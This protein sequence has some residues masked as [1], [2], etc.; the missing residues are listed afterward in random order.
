[1]YPKLVSLLLIQTHFSLHRLIVITSSKS[2]IVILCMHVRIWL[3]TNLNQ[4]TSIYPTRNIPNK[5]ALT[6]SPLKWKYTESWY[7]QFLRAICVKISPL[8]TL[9][10][11][12]KETIDKHDIVQLIHI[13]QS[14]VCM[15]V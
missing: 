6:F 3:K 15:P 11:R 13:L 12:F 7:I 4:S 5:N 10:V 9:S 14:S 1:M 8:C 2:K